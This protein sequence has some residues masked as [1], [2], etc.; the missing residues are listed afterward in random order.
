MPDASVVV[1]W[2]LPEE[3]SEE[4]LALAD[5]WARQGTTAVVPTLLWTEVANTLHQRTRQGDLPASAAREL[6]QELM[7]SGLETR[8]EVGLCRRAL[9][10]ADSLGLAA[11][12]DAVYLAVAET[13]G[14]EFW[15]FDRRLHS[16]VSGV[17]PWVR[18]AGG[19]EG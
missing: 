3:G 8:S 7:D 15:T 1:K 13:E 5:R 16:R 10:L 2:L 11:V 17:F 19:G 9:R 4:A 14:A 18:L 12:Y 6:L